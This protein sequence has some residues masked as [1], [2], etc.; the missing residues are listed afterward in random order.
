MSKNQSAE[1]EA[2]VAETM[3]RE[4]LKALS[5]L[6]LSHGAENDATMWPWWAICENEM[7]D[8]GDGPTKTG[9]MILVQGF[10]F[11]RKDAEQH[12][13][14]RLYEYGDQ[15]FVYCFSGYH[16]NHVR[17]LYEL[18]TEKDETKGGS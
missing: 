5:D 4:E 12:R 16:S 14:N 3:K 8:G 15:S 1:Q 17:E 7:H 11:N 10:W 6:V 9:R 2:R 18:A 13:K